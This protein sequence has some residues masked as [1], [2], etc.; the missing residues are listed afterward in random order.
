MNRIVAIVGRPNVGK[1]AVFNRILGRR[2]AIVHDE[3]GVTRDRVSAEARWRDQRFE[4]I[5]T[6]GLG[7]LDR[8]S[9]RDAIAAGTQSQAE[10]AIADASVILLV[11]DITA[12]LTPLDRQ[13]ATLLHQSGRRVFVAANKADHERLDAQAQEFESLGFP[14]YPVAALHHRGFDPLLQAV[15]QAL[16]AGESPTAANPLRVAIVGKPNAGKSSFINRVLRSDRVIVSDVPGT[17]RDSIEVPFV[18]GSGPQA[19][20]YRLIDTAGLRKI[21]REDH[22]IERFSIMRAQKSI[23]DADVVVLV[24]DTEQGP[25]AQDKKIAGLILEARK[26]CILLVN[27]WDLAMGSDLR[28]TQRAYEKAMR[29]NLY[30]LNFAP[31]VFVSSQSGLNVRKAIDVIDQVAAQISAT[32]PTSTLNRILHD[33]A[34]RVQAPTVQGKR[35]KFY[36][37]TQ[38]GQRPV[39]LRLYVNDP[40]RCT[41]SYRLYLLGQMRKALGLEGAPLVLEFRSSHGDREPR[42]AKHKAG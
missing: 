38:V 28:V 10:V 36:Y 32:V 33:A 42:Y 23:M 37:A 30:F 14:V 40:D 22:A 24:M 31:I 2:I 13:M 19:R 15:V 3:P 41:T 25:T 17:T 12:G 16:P 21:R 7:N 6:G 27:K 5:D 29:Q 1:S 11:V 18:I 4:L 34:K 8:S 39:R 9:T 26:G 20:H 35:L